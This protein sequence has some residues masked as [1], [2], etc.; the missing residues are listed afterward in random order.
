[1]DCK[2]QHLGITSIDATNIPQNA[3]FFYFW[4]RFWQP[5]F[6]YLNVYVHSKWSAIDDFFLVLNP[7]RVVKTG[8]YQYMKWYLLLFVYWLNIYFP[9][10]L[11]WNFKNKHNDHA[12][13]FYRRTFCSASA[14]KDICSQHPYAHPHEISLPLHH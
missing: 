14:S 12:V 4:I 1:M 7:S 11:Y 8:Y 9:S 2:H 3:K 13:K 5:E 10:H 6:S